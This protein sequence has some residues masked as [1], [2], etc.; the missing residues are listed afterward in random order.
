ML[1][2]AFMICAVSGLLYFALSCRQFDCFTV[3]FLSA[4][5]YFMPGA[6]RFVNYRT[7]RAVLIPSDALTYGVWLIVLIGILLGAFLVS[8]QGKVQSQ[9]V[10]ATTSRDINATR[11]SLLIAFIGLIVT[12]AT[13]K[14]SLF[15]PSKVIV[16]ESILGSRWFL[17]WI[18]SSSICATSAFL[19]KRRLLFWSAIA[20]L[21]FNMFVGY[22][23]SCAVTT[24][25]I[26][27]LY[28]SAKGAVC[29]IAN[30]KKAII[31]AAMLIVV[32]FGYKFVYQRVKLGDFKAVSKR[33]RDPKFY[34]TAVIASEP[35]M[36]QAILHK[37]PATRRLG[38]RLPMSA[39]R[40]LRR[41]HRTVRRRQPSGRLAVEPGSA[42]GGL[43]RIPGRQNATAC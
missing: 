2:V 23:S 34:Q 12:V 38:P 9:P 21:L 20:L 25:A 31:I 14:S 1:Y 42:A 33:I 35:F 4:S 36:T 41:A 7:G 37:G 24:I 27:L 28:F 32:F 3:A 11:I 22:R 5:V 43:G 30:R 6:F 26:F 29:L 16:Q 39:T 8:Q 19:L 10:E 13:S 18:T 40:P 17:L 15:S